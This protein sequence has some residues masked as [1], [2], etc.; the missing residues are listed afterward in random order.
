M[1]LGIKSLLTTEHGPRSKTMPKGVTP[2]ERMKRS[3]I[4]LAKNLKPSGRLNTD[5][6]ERAGEMRKNMS[7]TEFKD[8]ATLKKFN[9]ALY[10]G[11]AYNSL[12]NAGR[13]VDEIA[14]SMKAR[15]EQKKK[16]R[17]SAPQTKTLN[18]PKQ[19]VFQQLK[20]AQMRRK[21]GTMG[22]K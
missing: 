15:N 19:S 10:S 1:F 13:M 3:V 14:V 2:K 5:D 18:R 4:T 11:A 21:M 17:V 8:R 22:K 9:K 20:K 6:I 16:S 12:K 7:R